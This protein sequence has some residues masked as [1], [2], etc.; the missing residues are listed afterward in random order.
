MPIIEI[1]FDRMALDKVGPL[2]KT[3]RGHRYIL[4]LVDYATRY[5]EALPHRAATTKAVAKELMLL[6]SRVGISSEVLT[7]QGSCFMTETSWGR[8]ATTRTNAQTH[9]HIRPQTNTHTYNQC[10]IQIR[11]KGVQ[12]RTKYLKYGRTLEQLTC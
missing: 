10:Q 12:R 6:F 11:C 2:P 8:V 9:T 1:P 3:S 5:H 7:D 4:V